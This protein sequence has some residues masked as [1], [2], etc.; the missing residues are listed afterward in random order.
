VLFGPVFSSLSKPGHGPAADFPWAELAS[1]LA[2]ARPRAARIL[3][4]GGITAA[5]LPR[6]RELGFDGAAVLGAVWGAPDPVA[7]Y[8]LIRDVA[9]KLEGA[10]HAA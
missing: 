10:R 4:I 5:R 6:C 2:G 1:L 9:A 3:A 8:S 7:A